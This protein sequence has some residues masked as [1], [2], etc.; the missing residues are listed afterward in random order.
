MINLTI[1]GKQYTAPKGQNLLQAAL[2]NGIEIPHLCY[3]ENLSS[4]GG[5]RLCLVEVTRGKKVDLTTSCTY[6]VTQGIQVETDTPQVQKARR[7]MMEL[8]LPMAPNAP[9]IQALARELGVEY[10]PSPSNK[11]GDDCIKCGLCVRACEELV[12]ANSITFS[13]KGSERKVVPPFEEESEECIGC[14]TCVHVCPTGCITMQDLGRKRKLER[15]NRV[16]NMK[17]CTKCS[18]AYIPAAQVDFYLNRTG[19]AALEDWFKVCPDCR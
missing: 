6:P 9:R 16:L 12:G 15:W 7:L 18:N 11:K 2:D 4:Y 3:H 5:C 8:I 13:S 14:G 19:D 17:T 1:N 10:L